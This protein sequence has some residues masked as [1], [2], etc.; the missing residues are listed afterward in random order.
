METW[1]N[2]K[3]TDIVAIVGVLSAFLSACVALIGFRWSRQV[4]DARDAQISVLKEQIAAL[5][6]QAPDVLRKQHQVIINALNDEINSLRTELSYQRGKLKEKSVALADA[7]LRISADMG[8]TKAAFNISD[9]EVELRRLSSFIMKSPWNPRVF[10]EGEYY[11]YEFY[12]KAI[13][14]LKRDSGFTKKTV[15]KASE[16][17]MDYLF[18]P[19]LSCITN[20]P[21]LKDR[22][23]DIYQEFM[24]EINAQGKLADELPLYKDLLRMV[25]MGADFGSLQKYSTY[26][27]LMISDR[28]PS[29]Y[30]YPMP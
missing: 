25:K 2:L 13:E 18:Y 29:G 24:D 7:E 22:A 21:N 5:K 4:L 19:L 3:V 11:G 1:N 23:Y 6:D 8:V 9:Y 28:G 10:P 15:E 17:I 14:F 20:A 27:T 12:L 30:P 26:Q 16:W